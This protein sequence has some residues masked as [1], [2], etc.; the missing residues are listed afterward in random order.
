M[1]YNMLKFQ[2]GVAPDARIAL[3]ENIDGILGQIDPATTLAT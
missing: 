2:L 3:T 1:S